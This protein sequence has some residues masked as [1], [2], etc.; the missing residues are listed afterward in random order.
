MATK[1]KKEKEITDVYFILF[2]IILYILL[3][4]LR[5]VNKKNL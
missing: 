4:L 2:N 3:I 1:I 5:Y